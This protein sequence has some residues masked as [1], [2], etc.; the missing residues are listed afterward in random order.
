VFEEH[1]GKVRASGLGEVSGDGLGLH[2]TR[3]EIRNFKSIGDRQVINLSKGL[4]VLTGRNGSGKCVAPW[5]PVAQPWGDE[6]IE[7]LFHDACYSGIRINEDASEYVI[8]S[9]RVMI[10]SYHRHLKKCLETSVSTV[11]RKPYNGWLLRLVTLS[12]RLVEVTPEHRIAVASSTGFKWVKASLLTPG[13]KIMVFENGKI[14]IDV[15]DKVVRKRWTGM[16]YD[17]YVRNAGSYIIGGGVIVHNSNLV[18]AIRFALGENNPRLLRTDRLSSLVNDNAGKDSEAY[19]NLAIDN[20]DSVIPGQDKIITIARRMGRDGEST[21]YINGRRAPR[22]IIEDI[23]STAGLSARGYNIILQGEISRLADKNPVERRREIEQALGLAQY[24]EKKMEALNNLQ[25]ADNNLRVAQARLQEI[26]RRMLQ[27]ERERNLLLRRRMLEKEIKKVQL[28]IDSLEYWG[29]INKL[30][31]VSKRIE[32]NNALKNKCETELATLQSERKKLMERTEELLKTAPA[33]GDSEKIRLEYELKDCERQLNECLK[34][35]EEENL[36]LNTIKKEL[37]KVKKRRSRMQGKI[38]RLL[39]VSNRMSIKYSSLES[40]L[41]RLSEEKKRMQEIDRRRVEEAYHMR[42]RLTMVEKELE[43]RLVEEKSAERMLKDILIH[44]NGIRR[45]MSSLNRMKNRQSARRS[46]LIEKL[47]DVEKSLAERRKILDNTIETLRVLTESMDMFRIFF[48][49]VS[50]ALSYRNRKDK[51]RILELMRRALEEKGLRVYGVLRENLWFPEDVKKAV[52]SLAGEWMD[53]ILVENSLDMLVLTELFSG[54]ASGVRVLT[55]EGEVSKKEV[56]PKLNGRG[57]HIMDLLK[58]PK[59]IEKHVLKIFWHS[60]LANS[61]E[62]ALAFVKNGFKA[63]TR[64]GQVFINEGALIPEDVD[65]EFENILKFMKTFT[66]KAGEL[67]K[68]IETVETRIKHSLSRKIVETTEF[69]NRLEGELNAIDSYMSRLEEQLNILA[70]EYLS[71][72]RRLSQVFRERNTGKKR[73][74][75]KDLQILRSSIILKEKELGDI[76]KKIKLLEKKMEKLDEE[77]MRIRRNLIE[78]ENIINTLHRRVK[79]C[80]NVEEALASRI[81]AIRNEI[82]STMILANDLRNKIES[83]KANMGEESGTEYGESRDKR[84]ELIEAIR[85]LDKEVE[86]LNSEINR[87]KDVERRLLVEKEVNERRVEELRNRILGQPLQVPEETRGS[88]ERYLSILKSELEKVQEVNMLAIK[89]YEQEIDFYR[90]A[91]ERI[92]ELEE[93]RRSIQE[94]MEEIERK[95]REAF[96]E[97]LSKINNYFSTFFNKMAGGEGWLQPEDPDNPLETGL[98]VYVKFPGKEARVISG[99]SGGEKSVAALCLIFAMQ[100]LFPAAFYIFDEPDAHLDYV[101]I[102][103]MTDL[104]K[105]VSRGSQIIVISLRDIVVS[106][107]DKVIGV[108]VKKG[109]SRFMEMPGEKALEEIAV[110]G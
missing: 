69:R 97:G 102:D 37:R 85:K 55:P 16:V 100:K 62:D 34:K 44:Y 59:I 81:F 89:Q 18:D 53:A 38:K 104:L 41:S 70:S 26:D 79:E 63:V 20:S 98:N 48:A 52:E 2:L 92:N 28:I 80:R 12:G 57:K 82:R 9:Q 71:A 7:S 43:N 50:G 103:K 1:A 87:V 68:T 36:E 83:L 96:L 42:S 91:L 3:I 88:A 8:P 95:K 17:L 60:V 74:L 32:E 56:P 45:R 58:Y 40:L 51:K 64:D 108:Y 49:R 109:S 25:Q 78:I 75:E 24:D 10:L 15:L 4:T 29:L 30:N 11:F 77:K 99:V 33:I 101:N 76:R 105:E 19:V 110:A 90:N 72:S 35:T 84:S 93:E 13:N 5:M 27:L 107:A 47:D 65:R 6:L 46:R 23:I 73:L 31:D 66:V 61:V 54:E 106:K 21:Y 67:S 22:N 14:G 94:F 39:K 86:R